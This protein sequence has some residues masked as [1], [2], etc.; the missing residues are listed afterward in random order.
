V[1][2]GRGTSSFSTPARSTRS[3][4][5]HSPALSET[6]TPPKGPQQKRNSHILESPSKFGAP[7]GGAGHQSAFS[8]SWP[9]SYCRAYHNASSMT[10]SVGGSWAPLR[11]VGFPGQSRWEPPTG[12]FPDQLQQSP[13][14]YSE[15]T[16]ALQMELILAAAGG[17][18]ER[19]SNAAQCSSSSHPWELGAEHAEPVAREPACFPTVHLEGGGQRGAPK[20]GASMARTLPSGWGQMGPAEVHG[21][22]SASMDIPRCE[23]CFLS[24]KR[25]HFAA[26][27]PHQPW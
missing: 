21:H 18:P 4:T 25:K 9:D 2:F 20:P 26:W 10:T 1:A 13:Q 22:R 3:I 17:P 11:V 6:H 16:E 8:L 7:L 23:Q 24:H 15:L 12:Y 14:H 19:E 27:P 5:Q